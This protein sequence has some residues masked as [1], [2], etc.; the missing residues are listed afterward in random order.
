MATMMKVQ[1]KLSGISE[2]GELTREDHPTPQ[3]WPAGLHYRKIDLDRKLVSNWVTLRRLMGIMQIRIYR[4]GGFK[5]QKQNLP[6]C[7]ISA[8]GAVTGSSLALKHLEALCSQSLSSS[9]RSSLFSRSSFLIFSP[10]P[11]EGSPFQSTPRLE[12]V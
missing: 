10:P 6:S 4:G 11:G 1:I 3:H 12:V 5:A 8:A 9:P 2:A 7:G